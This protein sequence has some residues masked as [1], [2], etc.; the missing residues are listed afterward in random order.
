MA[1]PI[2][3][4]KAPQLAWLERQLHQAPYWCCDRR[5]ELSFY[6]KVTRESALIAQ[7]RSQHRR[8]RATSIAPYSCKHAC[9]CAHAC[10][11]THSHTL[12]LTLTHKHSR[13]HARVHTTTW[14]HIVVR[15]YLSF[16]RFAS[17]CAAILA[18]LASGSQP[19]PLSLA[20]TLS[21]FDSSFEDDV[22]PSLLLASS[23][24]ADRRLWMKASS[25][26]GG[27]SS[28][29]CKRVKL[30]TD[31]RDKHAIHEPAAYS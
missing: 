15:A 16:R 7:S 2:L 8:I 24:S 26:P 1:G 22:A 23:C 10:T 19:S 6:R 28:A 17:T 27:R 30:S 5:L 12:T 21:V 18:G 13:R 4:S 20:P 14:N 29:D 31:Y 3:H 25:E 9:T 11:H